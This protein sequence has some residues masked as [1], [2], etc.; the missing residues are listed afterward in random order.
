MTY[1]QRNLYRISLAA[2][3]ALASVASANA[4]V[5]HVKVSGFAFVPAQISARVG[6]TIEWVNG[7]FFS[8]TATARDGTWDVPLPAGRAGA[9]TVKKAGPIDYY[10]R[11]HPN[12]IGRIDVMKR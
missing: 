11:Y 3:L 9:L 4:D 12:M 8:H 6:D 10:C 7:D 5:I 1:G 2:A